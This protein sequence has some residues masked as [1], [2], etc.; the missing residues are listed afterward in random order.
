MSE[1]MLLPFGT[2]ALD[3]LLLLVALVLGGGFFLFFMRMLKDITKKSVK[4]GPVEVGGEDDDASS[5]NVNVYVG[6]QPNEGPY[7]S[8]KGVLPFSQH[9]FFKIMDDAMKG[10]NFQLKS[11]HPQT[12][13][14]Y[15]K[16][17]AF[18]H[19]IIN[20]KTKVF[21]DMIED[22]V[23]DVLDSNG[24]YT[25][26]AS[27]KKRTERAIKTYEDKARTSSVRV[28]DNKY[29]AHIPELMITKFSEWHQ[30]HIDLVMERLDHIL[31][32]QFYPSW[33]MKLISILDTF[34][35]IFEVT[36]DYAECSLMDLNGDLDAALIKELATKEACTE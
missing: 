22:Y 25:V 29:L 12:K 18:T 30:P 16:N 35:I 17:I 7:R 15:L 21:Y 10:K 26:L 28:E 5:N 20:C 3:L 36:F 6:D 24:E 4:L 34:E 31:Q 19:F 33:Q 2:K 13:H 9:R 14:Q 23:T 1:W 32:S 11:K 8:P 27:I